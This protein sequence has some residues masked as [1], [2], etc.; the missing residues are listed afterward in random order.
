LYVSGTSNTLKEYFNWFVDF[1]KKYTDGKRILDIACNDGTQLDSYKDA[2]FSTYGIDPAK[3][4]HGLSS[5]NHNVVCDYLTKESLEK[6]GTKFD[7][8]NAQNVFAHNTYPKE[9]LELCK[10]ALDDNGYIFIQTSQADM[11]KYNQF[12]TIYHE[13]ISFFSVKSFCTLAKS[14]G[15]NVVD[16]TRTNIHGTSFVFVLSKD[17]PDQSEKFISLELELNESVIENYVKSCK[18]ITKE[19]FDKVAELKNQGYKIIGF[20]A[21]AKGNTFLNFSK[22]KL[23]YIL[24][25]NPLKHNMFSPGS[26]IPIYSPNML[27]SETEKI[28]IMPLAWNFFKEIKEKVLSKR[29]ND[30]IFLKYFPEVEIE[31]A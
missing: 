12:D 21:A 22:I 11:V 27:L 23:D 13:H 3:N 15:L 4:L 26:K 30:I 8:I 10:T 31:S 20:G 28:C 17:E 1:T 25:D 24:D 7:V 29:S 14:A 19:T 2:G 6:L 18:R 16:V 9:F 5:K